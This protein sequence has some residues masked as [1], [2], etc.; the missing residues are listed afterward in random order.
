MG[1]IGCDCCF[2]VLVLAGLKF[3]S[4]AT[5]APALIHSIVVLPLQDLSGI[6]RRTYFADGITDALI[7]DLA[8]ISSL[9]VVSR[10]SAM[11]Y[12]GSHQPLPEIARELNVDA[13]VE[14]TVIRSGNRV[15]VNAQL[16][17]APSDRHLWAKTYDRSA[18]EILEVQQD[19][20]Q[21]IVN[22]DPGQD[23]TRRTEQ[24]SGPPA[25]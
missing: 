2:C 25:S 15:R 18:S 10:T 1:D 5:P 7:T 4:R 24:A 8:N 23:H 19:L 13:I 6:R 3:H 9:R 17:Q 14:G 22:G 20:A 12:K 21:S 11:H 16:V